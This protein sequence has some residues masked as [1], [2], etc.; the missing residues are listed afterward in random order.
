MVKGEQ[1]MVRKLEEKTPAAQK[2]EER[3]TSLQPTYEDSV[4]PE[5]EDDWEHE[6]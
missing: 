2:K 3:F 1:E 5:D 6:G 4:P